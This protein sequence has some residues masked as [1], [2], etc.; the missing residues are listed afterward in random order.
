MNEKINKSEIEIPKS[1]ISIEQITPTLTWRLRRD[2]LYP[3]QKMFEMEMEEDKD[4][5]HFGAFKDN[6]L[7]GV[8]SLFQKSTNFQFRKL[9]VDPTMQGTGIGNNLLAYITEYSQREGGS[10]IW[11]N[12][13]VSAIGFYLKAGFTQTGELFSRNGIDYEILEKKITPSSDQQEY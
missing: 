1:D 5:M 6:Q 10:R 3:G 8:V 13:R 7:V 4:G 11:C 12:A 2:V 9:A